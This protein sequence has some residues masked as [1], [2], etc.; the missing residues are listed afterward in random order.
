MD[1]E[2]EFTVVKIRRDKEYKVKGTLKYL[3]EYFGY[4][5]LCGNSY[6]EKI[7]TTPKTVKSLVS[8]LNKSVNETQ[9]GSYDPDCYFLEESK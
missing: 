6:N 9:R 5:L 4:T 7:T 2:K 1:M 8:N 3:T